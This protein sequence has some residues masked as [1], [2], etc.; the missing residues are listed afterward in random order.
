MGNGRIISVV[1]HVGLLAAAASVSACSGLSGLSDFSI[2]DQQWFAGS[3]KLFTQKTYEAAPLSTTQAVGPED[4]M[5]PDGMCAGVSAPVDANASA[6]AGQAAP[7][8][9]TGAVAVGQ[10]ECS[11]A[12]AM[13]IPP[14]NVNFST[15]ARGERVALATYTRGPRPGAYT[16]TAGRLTSMERVDVPEPPKPARQAK[17]K[18]KPAAT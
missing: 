4:L 6:D 5:S 3:N 10:T 15:D 14:D 12:R 9:A 18:K 8:A 7:P 16:F 13:G 2:K 17:P 11:V 1:K